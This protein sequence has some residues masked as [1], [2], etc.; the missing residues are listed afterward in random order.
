LISIH[1][2]RSDSH[3]DNPEGVVLP[4]GSRASVIRRRW[5]PSL[6]LILVQPGPNPKLRSRNSSPFQEKPCPERCF[7]LHWVGRGL[8]CIGNEQGWVSLSLLKSRLMEHRGGTFQNVGAVKY[9]SCFVLILYL[10]PSA[11]NPGFIL[12]SMCL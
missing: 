2:H 4:P 5:P 7:F 12:L 9:K 10:E 3:H 1:F 6:R 8:S 11:S